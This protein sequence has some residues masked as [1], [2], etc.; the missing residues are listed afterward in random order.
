MDSA[1]TLLDALGFPMQNY[2]EESFGGSKGKQK[3]DLRKSSSVAP[4]SAKED[5]AK[6]ARE[7]K[8]PTIS[9]SIQKPEEAAKS[10]ARIESRKEEDFRILFKSSGKEI[11]CSA[12]DYILDV[13]EEEGVEIDFSCRSGSCGTCKVKMQSGNVES[14]SIDGLN[15]DEQEE[16][17]V[18]TC[19][20]RPLSDLVFD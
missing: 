3:G 10:T 9:N 20:S 17:F 16:G 13:A 11:K 12:D 15:D 7:P 8:T 2:N 4:G 19:C 14:E 18:L 1:K 6:P 5:R